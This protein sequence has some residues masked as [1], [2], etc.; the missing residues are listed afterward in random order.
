MCGS[1]GLVQERW[2]V[3]N[4]INI[5]Q[6]SQCGQ[7]CD[8]VDHVLLCW[9]KEESTQL[10]VSIPKGHL[11]WSVLGDFC[12]IGVGTAV[13]GASCS[14]GDFPQCRNSRGM[15]LGAGSNCP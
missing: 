14:L 1:A 10:F 9:R 6:N 7:R 12:V 4:D 3:L 13:P 15:V 8:G 11:P 5:N 2:S